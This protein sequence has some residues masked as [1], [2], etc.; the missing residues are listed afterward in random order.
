[1]PYVTSFTSPRG[2]AYVII[3]LCKGQIP[4]P[5]SDRGYWLNELVAKLI[6]LYQTQRTRKWCWF[7]DRLTY[8]NGILPHALFSAYEINS[9]R[10]TLKIACESLKFLND[11]L[12]AA[13]YLNIVGNQ[14]WYERGKIRP[15]FDQQPVD[16]ASICFACY[17]AYRLVGKN[18]FLYLSNQAYNWYYGE[19]IHHIPLYC[20]SSGGCYDALTADGINLNQG[21]EAALSLLLTDQ[22]MQGDVTSSSIDKIKREA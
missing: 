11:I 9:D 14:G 6:A 18:E 2:I 15:L 10:K 5:D 22:L 13:G 8:C 3:A 4:W 20:E 16:A 12:F 7:E 19:N 21:A 17:E 1:L